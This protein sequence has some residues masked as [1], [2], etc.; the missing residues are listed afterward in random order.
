MV[1]RETRHGDIETSDFVEIL[2]PAAAE[3]PTIRS[4]RIDGD[5]VIAGTVQCSRQPATTASDVQDTS[6]RSWQL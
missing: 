6:R 1:K 3:D 4:L 2:D 5:D